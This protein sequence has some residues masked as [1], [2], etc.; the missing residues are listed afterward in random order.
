MS[1]LFGQ[2]ENLG[3]VAVKALLLYVTAVAGLRLTKR[4]VVAEL[5]LFDFVAAVAVGAIVGRTATA[6]DTSYITGA[7]A[8]LIVIIAHGAITQLRLRPGMLFLTD[9]APRILV[10][11]GKIH[12]GEL[13]RC[14]LTEEDLYATLRQHGITSLASIRYVIFE[15]K[16]AISVISRR[17]DVGDVTEEVL[18]RAGRQIR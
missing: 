4:R 16:G 3:W 15:A 13:R 12:H 7:V 1:L 2:I 9:H 18:K 14:G 6:A 11:E 5:S 8:L 10:T 17:H